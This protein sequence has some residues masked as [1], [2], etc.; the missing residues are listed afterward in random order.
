MNV[1]VEHGFCI[2]VLALDHHGLAAAS[3]RG[4]VCLTVATPKEKEDVR[5]RAQLVANWWPIGGPIAG[6]LLA[7]WCDIEK[8][9]LDIEKAW[10]DIEKAWLDSAKSMTRQYGG[11]DLP[12]GGRATRHFLDVLKERLSG[13]AELRR[14]H[15]LHHRQRLMR[16]H[17]LQLP[18]STA[19]P[20]AGRRRR[21]QRIRRAR[22]HSMRSAQGVVRYWCQLQL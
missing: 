5:K 10:L 2:G 7:N 14:Q 19:V 21:R 9:W 18:E 13:L 6:H 16:C 15:V 8:A 11:T 17:R 3:Q 22:Q 4:D 20:V 12:S 1:C